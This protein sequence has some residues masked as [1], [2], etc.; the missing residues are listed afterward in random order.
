MSIFLCSGISLLQWEVHVLFENLPSRLALRHF[1]KITSRP[2]PV[3]LFTKL[4]AHNSLKVWSRAVLMIASK[5]LFLERALRAHLL[6]HTPHTPIP[7]VQ[8]KSVTT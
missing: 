8:G 5:Y 1:N 4:A 7:L 2:P 3:V 6:K